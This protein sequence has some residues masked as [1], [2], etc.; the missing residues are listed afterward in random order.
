MTTLDSLRESAG[1]YSRLTAKVEAEREVRDNLVRDALTK[2]HR[3][4]TIATVA[5]ISR[6]YVRKIR[7]AQ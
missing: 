5:D 1:R 7:D 3:I 2:G 6:T 4:A